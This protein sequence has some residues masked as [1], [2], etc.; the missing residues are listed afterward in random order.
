[1]LTP[2]VQIFVCT[3]LRSVNDPLGC[4]CAAAGSSAVYEALRAAVFRRGRQAQVW[5]TRTGCMVH[6]KQGPTV[7]VYPAGDWYTRVSPDQAEAIVQR[8]LPD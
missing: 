3:N 8:Y 5:V 2:T 1:M 4:S 7:V 6:C